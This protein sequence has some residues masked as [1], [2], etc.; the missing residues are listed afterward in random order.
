M[1]NGQVKAKD[2]MA[3]EVVSARKRMSIYEAVELM[4]KTEVAGMPIVEDDI[5]LVGVLTEKDVLRLFYRD[6]DGEN[7]T[8][9]DYMTR[10]AVSFDEDEGIESICDFLMI[11]DLRRVP[12]KSREGEVVG[13]VSRSDVIDYILQVR[14]EGG[15]G[16]EITGRQTTDNG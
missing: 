14:R 10:P 16:R 12:V 4:R 1:F 7:K 3:K 8:V 6:E 9:E 15:E 13:I 2:V 11:S 5:G